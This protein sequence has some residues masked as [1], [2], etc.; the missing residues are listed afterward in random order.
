MP[1]D[2]AMSVAAWR[3][4]CL[5]YFARAE[6]AVGRSLEIAV[7]AGETEKLRHLAGQRLADLLEIAGRVGGT[8]KQTR[9]FAAALE[10]WQLVEPKRQFLAH[11]VASISTNDLGSW[12]LLL[13]L[14][15]YRSNKPTPDRWAIK[16]DEA[17]Q[18]LTQLADAFKKLSG[19]LGHLRKRLLP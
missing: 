13:D 7:E 15:I 9:A 3:G 17:H 2:A 16:Q 8:D 1:V 18:F 6:Q 12:T 10:A 11:G 19:Q 14:V 4:Q 5:N